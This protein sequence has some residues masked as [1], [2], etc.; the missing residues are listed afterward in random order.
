L[1]GE[2]FEEMLAEMTLG[3][4]PELDAG[5][6]DAVIRRASER[7]W[8]S[9]PRRIP[10]GRDV[11]RLLI[12]IVTIARRETFRPTAPYAPGVTGTALSMVDRE[13]LLKADRRA[14]IPGA[15]QLLDALGSALAYNVLSAEIDRAVKG[16]RYMVLYLNRLLCPRFG[17]PLGRGGFREKRLAVMAG[18]MLEPELEADTDAFDLE[19]GLE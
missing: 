14:R 3:R 18:W 5:R 15:D 13:Q 1:S 9:I 11:Q 10:H 2:L 17:L 6:Q 12:S 8:R 4:R 16:D 7:Y 19:L